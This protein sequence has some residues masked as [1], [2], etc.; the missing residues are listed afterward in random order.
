MKR[1]R[2]KPRCR[3]SFTPE[4][5]ADI[6]ELCQRSD[7]SIGQVANYIDLIQMAVRGWVKRAERDAGTWQ[8]GDPCPMDSKAL[9]R[10]C[11][12]AI[13]PAD[14]AGRAPAR[15]WTRPPARRTRQLPGGREQTPAHPKS[16]QQQA[17]APQRT[18]AVTGR[19]R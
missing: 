18:L 9:H 11:N 13:Y 8:D 14:A 19:Y 12:H 7:R 15:S 10:Q 6:V 4:F 2:K 16:G 5:K 3:R 1:M 17:E